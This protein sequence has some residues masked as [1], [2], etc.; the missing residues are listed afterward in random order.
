MIYDFIEHFHLPHVFEDVIGFVDLEVPVDDLLVQEK[1][2]N[3]F[4]QKIASIA[5][6]KKV[7]IT[8]HFFLILIYAQIGRTNMQINEIAKMPILMDEAHQINDAATAFFSNT[9][10]PYRLSIYLSL[11]SETKMAKK[12][13]AMLH[14]FNK[15]FKEICTYDKSD[16]ILEKGHLYIKV[17]NATCDLK[18]A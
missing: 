16:A 13:T 11:V 17:P 2:S 3:K 4:A 18:V 9:F 12:D 5:I 1:V 15:Y 7:F 10:S 14:S 6:R 8:N